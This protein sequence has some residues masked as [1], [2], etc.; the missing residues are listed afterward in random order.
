MLAFLTNCTHNTQDAPQTEKT[1]HTAVT[2]TQ[3]SWGKIQNEIV[4]SATTA[5]LD[6]SI[7]TTPIPAFI[8]DVN[9]QPGCMIRKGET[10]YTLETKEHH[11]LSNET[12]PS[13]IENVPVKAGTDGIVTAVMQQ[14]G[15]YVAEGTILCSLVVPSSL[16]FMLNVPYEQ[17][18]YASPGKKCILVLPDETRLTATIQTPLVTMNTTS[19]AQQV[20]ARAKSPFLP[21][22]MSVKVLIT[23]NNTNKKEEMILPKNAIQSNEMLTEH[24]VMKLANDS[25]AVKVPIQTG[26]CNADSIEVIS[27]SLSS[28]DRIIQ[29]GGYGLEDNSR[30][31]ITKEI[32]P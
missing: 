32:Q 18:E 15:S 26:N 22:G 1:P 4:L 21:E 28:A 11:A 27:P 16:V 3:V 5:Y 6:K 30:V 31:V 8:S 19:Q 17:Q 9:V 29:T 24:W 2:L 14:K 10:L 23:T 13:T 25:T 7:I 12:A 20:I